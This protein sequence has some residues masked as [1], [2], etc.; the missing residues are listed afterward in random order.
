[1]QSPF[2]GGVVKRI[3]PVLIAVGILATNSCAGTREIDL[4][5][6]FSRL[7]TMNE[8]EQR[9]YL[10]DLDGERV[11]MLAYVGDVQPAIVNNGN[12]V[13]NRLVPDQSQVGMS[14]VELREDSRGY[15]VYQELESGPN[16]KVFEGDRVSA[17]GTLVIGSSMERVINGE[18]F[19]WLEHVTV[20][21]SE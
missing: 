12:V 7:S 6:L 18:H 17:R 14:L 4:V 10:E 13:Q 1:M 16:T 19:A 5:S 8:I 3:G 9:S 2:Q 21:K 11:T 15:L 20:S